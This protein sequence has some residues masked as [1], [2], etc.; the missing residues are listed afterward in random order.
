[1]LSIFATTD[2]HSQ[3]NEIINKEDR[4]NELVDIYDSLEKRP[5]PSANTILIKN[6]AIAFPVDWY[7]V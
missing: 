7:N 3:L 6:G 1:M 4:L 5:T 2:F